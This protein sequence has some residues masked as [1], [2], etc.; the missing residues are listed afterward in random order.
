MPAASTSGDFSGFARQAEVRL[1][2][3]QPEPFE[4]LV[5]DRAR[6]LKSSQM[7]RQR[8]GGNTAVT[9]A[10]RCRH[11]DLGLWRGATL[12]T[13]PSCYTFGESGFLLPNSNSSCKI[14]CSAFRCRGRR[15]QIPFSQHLESCDREIAFQV[16]AVCYLLGKADQGP[17]S[18]VR[19]RGRKQRFGHPKRCLATLALSAL[20]PP[21]MNSLRHRRTVSSRTLKASA[22]RALVHP[23]TSTEWPER[24]RPP[25]DLRHPPTL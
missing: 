10:A 1:D 17:I 2:R 15:K 6:M 4:N 8:N 20:I 9:N 12:S 18:S 22:I 14:M 25:L 19:D 13:A 7:A 23:P 11:A 16:L 3:G 21:R 24:G 5:G